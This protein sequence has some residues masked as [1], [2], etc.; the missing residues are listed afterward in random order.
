VLGTE[1]QR[2]G[3]YEHLRFISYKCICVSWKFLDLVSFLLT[4]IWWY[5]E[6]ISLWLR[7]IHIWSTL[8]HV[9]PLEIHGVEW[10]DN[11]RI[12]NWRGFRMTYS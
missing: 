1:E 11:E 6:A 10:W 5:S 3:S 4:E 12:T 9:Q 7:F 2:S 8:G